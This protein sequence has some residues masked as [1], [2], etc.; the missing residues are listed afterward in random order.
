MR[1]LVACPTCK[2]QFDASTMEIGS[3]FR[4]RCGEVVVVP[5][6][7]AR[8]AAVVRCSSCGASRNTGEP[9]CGYCRSDFTTH[10]RDL[11]TICPSCFARIGDHARFCHH[12]A[13]PIV[14]E[15]EA[16]V[17]SD[18]TCP[19][20]G[21]GRRLRSRALG[22]ASLS[23]LECGSC[24]GLWLAEQAFHVLRDQARA[25]AEG[26][27]AEEV[28]RRGKKGSTTGQASAGPAYRPCPVCGTRMNKSNFGR[29]SG[30]LIDA[31]REH[32][33]WFD[34]HELD[35]ILSWIRAG[36][37]VLAQECKR[38][39]DRMVASANRFRV[40]PKGPQ[41]MMKENSFEDPFDDGGLLPTLLR[42][43][44]TRVSGG[45]L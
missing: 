26:T 25:G 22:E 42:I 23:A 9:L 11:H 20:C 17:E 31:C 41:D 5:K 38:Q 45:S 18:R 39:E 1:A 19:A 34:A 4:C 14:P 35:A 2:R 7:T 13:T 40:E 24:A 21:S 32:G 10:E 44:T 30:V 27:A 37:E 12:C 15:D 8:D 33:V 36:G 6:L 43:F 16:G 29:R 28:V 3:R